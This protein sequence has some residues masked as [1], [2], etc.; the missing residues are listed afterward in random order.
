MKLTRKEAIL[1][2]HLTNQCSD[3][4][5]SMLMNKGFDEKDIKELLNDNTGQTLWEKTGR[6]LKD[7]FYDRNGFY[8]YG[9][10]LL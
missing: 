6:V 4:L 2:S 3:T 8:V 5:R 1:L 10:E 9:N 7:K